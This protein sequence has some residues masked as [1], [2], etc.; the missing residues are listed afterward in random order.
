[1]A[2]TH[3]KGDFFD[4]EH[5]GIHRGFGYKGSIDRAGGGSASPPYAS[6]EPTEGTKHE[7]NPME[8]GEG[9]PGDYAMGGGIGQMHPHGHSPVH[10]EH[11]AN[12]SMIVHH[13][14]G[15]HTVHH[16]H[17]HV[18]HHMHDGAPVN[19]GMHHG[20]IESMHDPESEYAFGGGARVAMPHPRIPRGMVPHAERRHSEIGSA[21]PPPMPAPRTPPMAGGGGREPYGV[22]PSAEPDPTGGDQGIP[23]MKRGGKAKAK[24]KPEPADDGDEDD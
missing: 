15:G 21:S 13:A 20:G 18:S 19:G 6:D 1:M 14:H 7:V 2:V 9:G 12:G 5:D 10:I 24:A 11:S 16:K 4:S 17:G 8:A 3:V 23:Q 22:G